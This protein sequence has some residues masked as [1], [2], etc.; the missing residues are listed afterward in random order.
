MRRKIY[1]LPERIEVE[2]T[3]IF[4][5]GESIIAVKDIDDDI[6]IGIWMLSWDCW[7]FEIIQE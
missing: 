5:N 3:Y 6:W 4:V 7:E 2:S 1:L